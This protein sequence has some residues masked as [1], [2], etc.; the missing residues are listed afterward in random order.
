[1]RHI[2]EKIKK[3]NKGIRVIKKLNLSLLRSSW[4]TM[5]QSFVRP[6][7]DYGNIIYDQPNNASLSEKVESVQYY[8]A[9]AIT[10]AIKGT[11]KEKLYQELRLE[12][13]KY[14][15]WLRRMCYLLLQLKFLPIFMTYF[16][17][18]KGRNVIQAF[19]P[20]RYRTEL[21]QNSFLPF[22]ISEWNKLDPDVRNVDTYSLF[23]KNLLAFVAPIEI[24][25]IAFMIHLVSN[26]FT[27]YN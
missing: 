3:A 18:S 15:R 16:L 21:S 7:S 26:F 10:G 4:M 19:K 12:S 6:H 8:A 2:N 9:L 27:D 5:Y 17:P 24:N 13:S 22:T 20:L 25:F 14:R 11:S 1:M 23:C